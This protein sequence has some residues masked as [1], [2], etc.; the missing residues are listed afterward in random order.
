[1]IH[2]DVS[3]MLDQGAV[4]FPDHKEDLNKKSWYTPPGMGG[5]LT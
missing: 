2:T 3:R 4:I 5:S 1:M